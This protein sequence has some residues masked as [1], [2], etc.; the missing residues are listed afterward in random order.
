MTSL[1]VAPANADENP[2]ADDHENGFRK[3]TTDSGES[4]GDSNQHW[5]LDFAYEALGWPWSGQCEHIGESDNIHL[6][7]GDREVSVHGWWLALNDKCPRKAD[8]WVELQAR[9]CVYWG[10]N[11]YCH[12]QALDRSRPKRIYS[13]GGSANRVN[14]RHSC[15][16]RS[17][18]SFRV[19]VDVDIPGEIDS[20]TKMY[21][22][23]NLPCY[24][25][26]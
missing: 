17:W 14:A 24:P 20:S 6:S 9:S 4:T 23:F 15:I 22:R 21:K 18:V 10:G 8:V 12:W 1:A 2:N 13:G 5:S 19:V 16:S 7:N 3:F 11:W 25:E 26:G